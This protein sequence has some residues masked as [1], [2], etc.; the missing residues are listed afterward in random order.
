M[1]ERITERLEERIERREV[2]PERDIDVS[3][4]VGATL[5]PRVTLNRLPPDIVEVRPQYRDYR[6]VVSEREIVIVDPDTRRVV[7]V[8]DRGGRRGETRTTTYEVFERRDDV[9]RWRRPTSVT[10]EEGVVLP[11]DAPF[12]DV[13]REVVEREPR[14][15][16][17]RYVRTQDDTIAIVEPRSRRVVQV[18]DQRQDRRSSQN[19]GAAATTGSL[20]GLDPDD[21]SSI[22]RMIV[23][24]AERGTLARIGD[25]RGATLPRDIELREIPDDVVALDDELKRY[26]YVLVGDDVLIVDPDNRRIVDVIE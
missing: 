7:E 21:R 15:R 9:R 3:I 24:N 25:L 16:G 1:R 23:E 18:V 14:W 22:N 2:R 11:D 5:P 6:Y 19:A 12:Y 10:I 4:N 26:R 17:Y 8:I 20:A 13:P